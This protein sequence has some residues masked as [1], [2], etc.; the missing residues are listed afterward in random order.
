MHIGYLAGLGSQNSCRILSGRPS[1]TLGWFM[2]QT[3]VFVSPKDSL[4]AG[5]CSVQGL[6]PLD[7]QRCVLMILR[8]GEITSCLPLPRPSTPAWD[9]VLVSRVSYVP[10]SPTRTGK[11]RTL[12]WTRVKLQ[13]QLTLAPN[14]QS[15]GLH[16][17][18]TLTIYI[19]LCDTPGLISV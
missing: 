13:L 16:F 7:L 6:A 14:F 9:Q 18:K 8:V 11:G 2:G 3:P 4:D 17:P 12:M 10:D 5:R 19:G 15:V 1:Q